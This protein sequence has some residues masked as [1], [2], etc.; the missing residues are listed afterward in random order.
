[1]R[2]RH[3][4]DLSDVAFGQLCLL[5]FPLATVALRDSFMVSVT[6]GHSWSGWL[7]YH[8][9]DALREGILACSYRSG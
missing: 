2:I 4:K 7:S 3:Q 8:I 9:S 5:H 6:R 1:M